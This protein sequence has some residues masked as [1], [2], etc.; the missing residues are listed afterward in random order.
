[1]GPF[2]ATFELALILLALTAHI[3]FGLL[4][5]AVSLFCGLAAIM[6]SGPAARRLIGDCIFG[7]AHRRFLGSITTTTISARRSFSLAAGFV[8][9]R[10]AQLNRALALAVGWLFVALATP[11]IGLINHLFPAQ[12]YDAAADPE[13]EM[14]NPATATARTKPKRPDLSRYRVSQEGFSKRF[15]PVFVAEEEDDEW[16]D[17]VEHMREEDR[18]RGSGRR[19][20]SLPLVKV[21][22]HG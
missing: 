4:A 11:L 6:S 22:Y 3:L 14:N 5:L 17:A 15:R 18:G 20:M 10:L 19:G 21:T 2:A 8:C 1:M 9:A 13:S 7:S 16:F 12:S